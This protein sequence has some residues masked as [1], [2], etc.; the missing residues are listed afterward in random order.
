[1]SVDVRAND[2]YMMSLVDVVEVLGELVYE[3]TRVRWFDFDVGIPAIFA[4]QRK[5]S[6]AGRFL[7]TEVNGRNG[8]ACWRCESAFRSTLSID[9]GDLYT[10][11]EVT[12]GAG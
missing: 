9:T 6:I 5:I 11:R 4:I 3:N 12:W 8:G 10:S 1:M 7:G 2:L